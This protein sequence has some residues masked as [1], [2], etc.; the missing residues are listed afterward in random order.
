MLISKNIKNKP[1]M[2]GNF[3]RTYVG[4]APIHQQ[5][6]QGG[7]GCFLS[8]RTSQMGGQRNF[9]TSH[10]YNGKQQPPKGYTHPANES[11]HANP[12][13][14]INGIK[15]I[16]NGFINPKLN[17]DFYSDHHRYYNPR[18]RNNY[19]MQR[20]LPLSGSNSTHT[21]NLQTVVFG[22][23]S[24]PNTMHPPNNK[25]K[26]T[27]NP[28]IVAIFTTEDFPELPV[29]KKPTWIPNPKDKC[30][31]FE[32]KSKP[33][34]KCKSKTKANSPKMEVDDDFVVLGRK[35]APVK[36]C[37][38]FITAT[39]TTPSPTVPSPSSA[40]IKSTPPTSFGNFFG[41]K[42]RLRQISECSDDS[43]VICFTDDAPE[44][45]LATDD[46]DELEFSCDDDEDDDDDD[47]NDDD[48][49]DDDD[50]DE[51]DN[52]LRKLDETNQPDSGFDDKKQKKV[53]FNLKPTVH[54]MYSWDYAYRAARK[55]HWENYAIDRQ[56]FK[57]RI[58]N[59]SEIISPILDTQHREK[60]YRTRFC[61]SDNAV[62]NEPN[63]STT[64]N[65]N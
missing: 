45:V 61:D 11:Y 25:P 4:G 12:R 1:K 9:S 21:P 59:L 8:G 13:G 50:I 48:E 33:R 7:S 5:N 38:P 40:S 2:N 51:T 10:S 53:R 57:Q 3:G 60:I 32:G 20:S 17:C 39:P 28:D 63:G 22:L 56:R 31:Y 23:G 19:R 62:S 15:N 43:F 29:C 42:Q 27:S 49:D 55:R 16:V 52:H 58:D 65:S 14:F 30:S 36:L 44:G 18:Y 47:G 64:E 34:D 46:S 6:T 26:E 41:C 37:D 54:V 24:Y 35:S